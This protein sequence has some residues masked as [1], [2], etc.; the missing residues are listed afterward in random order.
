[1]ILLA[2]Q[3]AAEPEEINVL[4][5]AAAALFVIT[6][7]AVIAVFVGLLYWFGVFKFSANRRL[8]IVFRDAV[9]SVAGVFIFLA[10]AGSLVTVLRVLKRLFFE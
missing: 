9:L 6:I 7:G 2:L 1:M 5:S 10:L 4:L 8:L 3:N